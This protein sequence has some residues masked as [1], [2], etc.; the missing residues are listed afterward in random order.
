MRGNSIISSK[1]TLP[2]IIRFEDI[3]DYLSED[4]AESIR[5]IWEDQEIFVTVKN[6]PADPEVGIMMPYR[7][8][9]DWDRSRYNENL[10][11]FESELDDAITGFVYDNQDKFDSDGYDWPDYLVDEYIENRQLCRI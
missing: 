7:E 1:V 4:L 5:H 8:V 6:C 10:A 2:Y 11:L 9:D 3:E